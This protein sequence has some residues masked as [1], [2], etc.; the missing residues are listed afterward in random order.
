MV[1][2][3]YNQ[4]PDEAIGNAELLHLVVSTVDAK[5]LQEL[6]FRVVQGNLYNFHSIK[7][8]DR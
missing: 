2:G 8:K 3:V 4:F 6:I 7:Y 1:P 5:Q